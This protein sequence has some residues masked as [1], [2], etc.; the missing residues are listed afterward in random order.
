MF[1]LFK[2]KLK[3]LLN[4]DE[5]KELKQIE[6]ENYMIE[7]RKLVEIRGKERANKELGIKQK[8]EEF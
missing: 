5:L 7:A 8:K 3:P 6:R 2:K 1:N 4:E